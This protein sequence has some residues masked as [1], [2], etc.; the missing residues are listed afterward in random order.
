MGRV[1]TEAKRFVPDILVVDDGSGDESGSEAA[2][3]GARVHVRAENGGKGLALRDGIRVLLEDPSITHVLLM[4][5][6]G[7]HAA[8]DIP[9]FLDAARAGAPFV[10]GSRFGEKRKI[11]PKRFWANYVGSRILSRMTGQLVEDTQSGYRM[12]AA[13]VLTA[14]LPRLRSTGYAI[15]SEILLKSSSIGVPLSHVQI[16]AIYDGNPSSFRPVKDT[17]RISWLCVGFKVFD[18]D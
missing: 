9:K 7:Q 14:I 16:E 3:A 2:A 8:A 10:I 5:A 17:W 18:E 12:I 13:P 4:D 15:E 6:D 11:P 1:V